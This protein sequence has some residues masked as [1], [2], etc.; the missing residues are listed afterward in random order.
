MNFLLMSS[1]KSNINYRY[2][3]PLKNIISFSEKESFLPRAE[4]T[5]MLQLFIFFRES[6]R[7]RSICIPFLSKQR[8]ICIE[9][10]S[11]VVYCPFSWKVH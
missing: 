8:Q 4:Q 6:L 11:P 5:E 7:A 9:A 10:A 3:V 1:F 2:K